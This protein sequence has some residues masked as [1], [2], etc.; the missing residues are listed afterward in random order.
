MLGFVFD[1]GDMIMS[2]TDTDSEAM[3]LKNQRILNNNIGSGGTGDS[4]Y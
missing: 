4:T 1:V 2:E 3:K